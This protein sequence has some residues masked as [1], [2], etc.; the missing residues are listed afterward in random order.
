MVNVCRFMKV[1][2]TL[3]TG[4]GI[5]PSSTMNKRRTVDRTLIGERNV[6]YSYIQLLP[7]KFRFKLISLKF[8]IDQ[9][10]V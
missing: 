8:Q 7:D 5:K 9:F 2:Q 3:S 1:T 4:N 10:E 6:V